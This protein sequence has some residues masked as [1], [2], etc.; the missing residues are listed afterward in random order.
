MKRKDLEIF[1]RGDPD[2]IFAY[3]ADS[4]GAKVEKDFDTLVLVQRAASIASRLLIYDRAYKKAREEHLTEETLDDAIDMGSD[5]SELILGRLGLTNMSKLNKQ[6]LAIM[7]EIRKYARA[8]KSEHIVKEDDLLS[9]KSYRE[10]LRQALRTEMHREKRSG[11]AK[12]NSS[13]GPVGPVGSS[14]STD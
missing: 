14:G 5:R 7:A 6:L 4:L 9:D 3:L 2:E 13:D 10:G 1:A 8:V 12:K 11:S